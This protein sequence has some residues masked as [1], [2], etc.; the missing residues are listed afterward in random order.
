MVYCQAY[1]CRNRSEKGNKCSFYR[2]PDPQKRPEITKKWVAALKVEKFNK[3]SSKFTRSDVVCSEHFTDDCFEK[4]VIEL[5]GK[6]PP[7]RL[8]FDAV[9]SIFLHRGPQPKAR[10]STEKR[11]A[12]MEAQKYI[13]TVLAAPTSGNDGQTF[14]SNIQSTHTC[15]S[16]FASPAPSLSWNRK[17]YVPSVCKQATMS[18]PEMDQYLSDVQVYFTA[19]EW[20]T[21]S[22]YE[23]ICIKN[24]KENYEMV[25]KVGLQVNPPMFMQRQQE[26][27]LEI[28]EENDSEDEEMMLEPSHV[29]V[30]DEKP[31][32]IKENNLHEES[33]NHFTIKVETEYDDD[34]NLLNAHDIGGE[35][36]IG[37]FE[38]KDYDEAIQTQTN[39]TSGDERSGDLRT[40]SCDQ[41]TEQT[42]IEVAAGG[43]QTSKQS[44]D[45]RTQSGD[46]RTQSGDLNSQ[47]CDQRTE[48]TL[49]EVAAGGDQTSKQSGDLRTQAGDLNSQSCDQKTEQTLIEVAAGDD[50]TSKQSGDLRTQSGDLNSQSCD[51]KTEQTLTEVAAGGDQTSKQS[52]DLRTQSGDLRTQSCDQRTEQ[53]LIEV[54]AGG[55]QTSKQSGD[56]RTQSGD[57]NSQSCDQKT[58]QTLTGGDQTPKQSGDLRTQS[59]D[60]NSQS[61]DQKKEQTLIEVAPGGD[62]TP[63]QSRP[64]YSKVEGRDDGQNGTLS[65][66]RAVL[67][68]AELYPLPSRLVYM[69]SHG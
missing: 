33:P 9:P 14:Q 18:L 22:S 62:Q 66:V 6:V 47:S 49:I 4:I 32:D 38:W 7:K 54:A 69:C 57:L 23:R 13:Q 43:D 15:T 61:C 44:G 11:L 45:L 1:G 19:K 46:L 64:P 16:A 40:Q 5:P 30:N 10:E 24:I 2:I 20:A 51:Q 28:K 35:G 36:I 41:R 31:D 29:P 34:G 3:P 48:Q 59:G 65:G 68:V 63:K 52:G 26:I 55:D 53:T 21:F 25:N 8:K 58:E 67:L 50:Q 60:L 27:K 56:L 39:P 42:L 12:R 37:L 17:I